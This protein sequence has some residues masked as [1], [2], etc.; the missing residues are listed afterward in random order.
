MRLLQQ[1]VGLAAI[2]AA[3]CGGPAHASAAPPS[4]VP[5]LAAGASHTCVVTSAS[6]VSCWGSNVDGQLGDGNTGD[7][8]VPAT[9]LGIESARGVVA[10]SYHACAL[11]G[12][13]S[14]ECWGWNSYGQVGAQA[15]IARTTAAPVA[16]L[17]G[18][19]GVATG[20]YHSCALAQGGT[21]SCWGQND[22]GQ[23]GDGS[24]LDRDSPAAVFSLPK[25][26][27]I[28]AGGRHSCAVVHDGFHDGTVQCWGA[29]GTGE[30][31]DGS[32]EERTFPVPVLGLSD[33]VAVTA[34]FTHSCALRQSGRILC[35]GANDHGQLGDGGES[36]AASSVPV[37]VQGLQATAVAAGYNHTCAILPNGT[38]AC[39][40]A[41][42]AGQLGDGTTLDR[43]EPTTV[44]GLQGAAHIAG[45]AFHTCA[46]TGAGI[47]LCWGLNDSGQLGDGTTAPHSEPAP[48]LDLP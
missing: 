41:N 34:G 29:N 9:V 13:G 46:A 3:G 22:L 10:G 31:G 45:G 42:G 5:Q 17:A 26:D 21:G 39:W 2:C 35:W 7:Q 25:S 40:G 18:V 44:R 16:D 23:L 48:V 37:L 33:A 12:D 6:Q 1:R 24:S 32:E 43:S 14:A 27:V 15:S 28:A 20:G 30:L 11:I 36:G 4:A 8:S 38:V 19:T 47:V